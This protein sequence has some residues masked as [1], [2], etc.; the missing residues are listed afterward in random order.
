MGRLQPLHQID[1]CDIE[2]RLVARKPLSELVPPRAGRPLAPDIRAFRFGESGY[3]FEDNGAGEA[4]RALS[5][6]GPFLS[7]LQACDDHGAWIAVLD[8]GLNVARAAQ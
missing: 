3:A 4:P 2:W 5:P 8:A 7:N 1:R 6:W